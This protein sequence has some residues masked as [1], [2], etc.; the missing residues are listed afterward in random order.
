MAQSERRCR[1]VNHP[2]AEAYLLLTL[3]VEDVSAAKDIEPYAVAV[4]E[5]LAYVVPIDVSGVVHPML[6]LTETREF[7]PEADDAPVAKWWREAR[8]KRT[9][10]A[11][12]AL[13]E[14]VGVLDAGHTIMVEADQLYRANLN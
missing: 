8:P 1:I 7:P 3:K 14:D 2:D 6:V 4:T 12:K 11:L 9:Y 13:I 10:D 5:G